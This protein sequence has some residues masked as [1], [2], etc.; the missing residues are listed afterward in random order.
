MRV[1]IHSSSMGCFLASSSIRV[2]F[3]LLPPD[4]S[5]FSSIMARSS[6]R[7]SQTRARWTCLSQ[8]SSWWGAIIRWGMNSLKTFSKNASEGLQRMV[9]IDV[10]V[11]CCVVV[12]AH[13][14]RHKG[15]RAAVDKIINNY[16]LTV[17]LIETCPRL[18]VIIISSFLVIHYEFG[19]LCWAGRWGWCRRLWYTRYQWRA[20]LLIS[21]PPNEWRL[22][23]TATPPP[24][25][26]TTRDKDRIFS[27]CSLE[28][29]VSDGV[30][31]VLKFSSGFC[32]GQKE[33]GMRLREYQSYVTH[34]TNI[35]SNNGTR[36]IYS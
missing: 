24:V 30:F 7:R 10:W 6:L 2:A 3:E 14:C 9:L 18:L 35:V 8:H 28:L 15:D 25:R 26:I 20:F 12:V 16:Y 27:G 17:I 31:C 11:V 34:V 36:V 21:R 5:T 19:V 33:R 23:T 32:C 13:C 4:N 29:L 1:C 22:H